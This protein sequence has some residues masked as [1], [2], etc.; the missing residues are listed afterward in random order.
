MT[1]KWCY[2]LVQEYADV[3]R[4]GKLVQPKHPN[5]FRPVARVSEQIATQVCD[6][7]SAS[8]AG[9]GTAPMFKFRP[10]EQVAGRKS[11]AW[12]DQINTLAKRAGRVDDPIRNNRDAAYHSAAMRLLAQLV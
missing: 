1:E 6:G 8:F 3:D 5:H 10:V 4:V 2:V 12:D 9:T 11:D 7:L